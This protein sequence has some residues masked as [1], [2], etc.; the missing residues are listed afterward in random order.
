MT[1]VFL[2][3]NVVAKPVTRTIL[4]VGATRSGLSVGWSATAE[5]EAARHMRPRATT[6]ADVRRRYGGEPTPTGDIAGRFEATESED[7]Q[8]LADAEA[9][10]ARF[11]ITEDVDDYGLADLA[12]VGISA[13][14]P[15]LFLAERLTREAYSVVIQRFVELQVNPPTTPEQFHAAIAKNHPRL[16]AAHADLYDIA[17][18]LSVHPE[19]AV[20]FRGTRC[21]RCERI[22]G[23]PAAI[24]D[25]LGPECR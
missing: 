7:R 4:M 13:V 18:E 2:D 3:A 16:F 14:N 12:S 24:I 5:A 20:I 21:L 8:I 1:I 25:G 10:G 19:P 17:P 11:L 9:A 6:P 23:D 22:V 15:D